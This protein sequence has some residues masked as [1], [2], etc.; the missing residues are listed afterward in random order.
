MHSHDRA[1]ALVSKI[2]D[3]EVRRV[4]EKSLG[5][6]ADMNLMVKAFHLVYG[7]P[8]VSPAQAQEDFKHMTKERLAMRFGL[9]VEEFMELCEAMDFRAEIN[10][11][12]EDEDGHF[13]A[14]RHQSKEL[15][16]NFFQNSYGLAIAHDNTSDDQLHQIVRERLADVIQQTDER[17]IPDVA[18]AL[19]D[20]KY[21]ITGF[22]YEV[23]IEPQFCAMEGQASNLSKLQEDGTVK[24]RA[25]GKV[26]KGPNYFKPDMA[27]ALR[28]WDMRGL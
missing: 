16:A 13:K 10:F 7:M 20:L 14:A 28:S 8:I 5:D 2:P 1:M 25:D 27:K 26:L 23:G 24:Y 15:E 6:K 11:F 9:I 19:F 17:S 22:E 18:D 4:A 21:V 3:P 12:Y